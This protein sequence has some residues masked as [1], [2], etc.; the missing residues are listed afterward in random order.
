MLQNTTGSF[1]YHKLFVLCLCLT[2]LQVSYY[3]VLYYLELDSYLL[4]VSQTSF[5]FRQ[6]Q[7]HSR[8][9]RNTLLKMSVKWIDNKYA[10]EGE[11]TAERVAALKEAGAKSILYLCKDTP[12]DIG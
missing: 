9:I 3:Q 7:L 6:L 8:S 1:I 4:V 12:Q 5:A 2:F 10:L 11:L